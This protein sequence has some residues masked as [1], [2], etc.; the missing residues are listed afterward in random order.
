MVRRAEAGVVLIEAFMYRLHPS[1]VA[2]AS[3]W[4]RPDRAAER[5]PQLV[6][7]LQRRPGQHPQHRRVRWRR[8]VRHRLL[9]RSTSR[10]CCS[11][12]SRSRAGVARARPGPGVDTL[13]SG[14][15]A[16]DT[17][18]AS[19]TVSTRTETDQRVH[20]YGT[21]WPDLARNPVQHPARPADR[22]LVTAGGDPP[23]APATEVLTSRP[24]ISTP[25]KLRN[26]P[27]PCSTAGPSSSRP[28]TPSRTC[29]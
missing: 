28:P 8:A 7:L 16:F 24:P 4:R 9:L 27:P 3:S 29:A 21:T 20:I 23:V 11:V 1:W 26:S 19:F 13:T 15:L 5:R 25:P 12:A 10:G 22:G 14:I 18:I 6:R 2:C 17:G